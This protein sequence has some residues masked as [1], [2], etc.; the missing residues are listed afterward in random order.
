MD[1]IIIWGATGQAIVLEELLSSFPVSIEAFFENNKELPSPV[2]NVPI[3]YGQE[4]FD[5]WKKN[6]S[7]L[8]DY[9]FIVAIG[10]NHGIVR[11]EIAAMFESNGL[12]P[13]SAVHK[14]AY[15]AGNAVIGKGA[16]ILAN[17]TICARAQIGDYCIINTGADVDH[18]CV[19]GNGVHISAEAMLAGYVTVK[20]NSFVGVNATILP[21]III[22][23]NTIVGAGAVVTKNVSD[24]TVVA[25]NPAKILN[26]K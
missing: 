5:E 19:L 14:T 3:Y 6:I 11:Q 1:K 15:V 9:Y 7:D 13:Y 23:E 8:S 26:Q 10:G 21:R 4:G 25:G 18:E 22:G 17:S 20:D 16:Q 12:K 2:N 24:N